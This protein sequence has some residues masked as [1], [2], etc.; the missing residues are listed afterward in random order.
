MAEVTLAGGIVLDLA[1]KDDLLDLRKEM[2]RLGLPIVVP[3]RFG[4]A[5]TTPATAF[6]YTFLNAGGPTQ[7][8]RIWDIRRY[9]VTV[10]DPFATS[11]VVVVPFIGTGAEADSNQEPSA[12][13]AQLIDMAATLGSS[14]TASAT[15]SRGELT[16]T[17]PD[18]LMFCIKSA[19]NSTEYRVYGQADEWGLDDR[20]S[21][22]AP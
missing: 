2:R 12:F 10:A 7:N 1:T 19:A 15:W 17:F 11:T 16:L 5:K 4:T 22:A 18:K 20:L 8:G 13:G 6:T 21:W 9:L 3:R 14:G